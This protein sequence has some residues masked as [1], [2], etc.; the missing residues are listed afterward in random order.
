[1]ETNTP[2]ENSIIKV[3]SL[4]EGLKL[5]WPLPSGM[6]RFFVVGF[7]CFWLCGWAF[8]EVMVFRELLAGRANLFMFVWLGGWTVGG[9]FAF[10][11][12]WNALKPMQPESVQLSFDSFTHSPGFAPLSMGMKQDRENMPSFKNLIRAAVPVTLNRQQ[13]AGGFV[14]D[15]VGE[16][17][18]LRYDQGA[19][20]TEIG[21]VL[22][23]PER[24]WLHQLLVQ[25]RGS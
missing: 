18:R 15:R 25:W 13:L 23:E 5:S 12:V 17:Q 19:Q 10:L 14:L 1:M 6:G 16:R 9:L 2:P 21:S 22:S 20:R 11:S 8:G 4:P 7:L 24:E 3:E